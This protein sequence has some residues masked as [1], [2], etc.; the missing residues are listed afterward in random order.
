MDVTKKSWQAHLFFAVFSPN[1]N[2]NP[3]LCQA[4]VPLTNYNGF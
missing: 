2:W 3:H 1:K 4:P